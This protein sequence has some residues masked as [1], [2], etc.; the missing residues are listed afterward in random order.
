MNLLP[1]CAGYE[2]W[3]HCVLQLA[4]VSPRAGLIRGRRDLPCFGEEEAKMW[5]RQV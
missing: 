5:K 1:L 4:E 3:S 2:E